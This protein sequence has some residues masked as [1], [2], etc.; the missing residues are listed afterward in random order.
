MSVSYCLTVIII[1]AIYLGI[2]IRLIAENIESLAD[3]GCH[4]VMKKWLDGEK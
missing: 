1:N 4:G 3:D 2:V